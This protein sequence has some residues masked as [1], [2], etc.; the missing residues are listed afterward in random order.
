MAPS[1]ALTGVRTAMVSVQGSPF[2]V[3]ATPEGRWAFVAV[4]GGVEV[5]WAGGS[6]APAVVRTIPVA[7][8]PPV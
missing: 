8:V 4:P 2:G 7:G 6:L 1:A 5:L 3:A